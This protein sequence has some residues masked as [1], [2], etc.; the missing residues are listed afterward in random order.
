VI[1]GSIRNR[2]PAL[3]RYVKRILLL[4]VVFS[5]LVVPAMRLGYLSLRICLPELFTSPLDS[6]VVEDLCRILELDSTDSRCQGGRIYAYE[7]FS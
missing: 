6:S 1:S 7:F 3:K 5:C 2:A 4:V